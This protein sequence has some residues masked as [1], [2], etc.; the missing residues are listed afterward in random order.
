MRRQER[1]HDGNE[2]GGDHRR[3][4]LRIG[5]GRAP[6]RGGHRGA[7]LRGDDGLLGAPDAGG[8]GPSPPPGPPPPRGS[9]PGPPP[10]P[11]RGPPPPP[12]PPAPAAPPPPR[13][14]PGGLGAQ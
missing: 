5:D 1:E 9:P 4:P 12:P 11:P 7:C 14:R 13:R 6:A 2:S 3:V 8:G 10:P